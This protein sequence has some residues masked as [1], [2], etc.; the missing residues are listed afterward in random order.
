MNANPATIPTFA[1]ACGCFA[2]GAYCYARR[3]RLSLVAGALLALPCALAVF[4]YTHLLDHAVWYFELRTVP[5]IELAFSGVGFLGGALY[6]CVD[7]ES[8]M[9]RLAVPAAFAVIVLVPF[10]KPILEPLNVAALQDK[11]KGTVCLQSSGSTCGPA[12]AATLLRGLGMGVT[13]R[14]LAVESYTY[15]GGTE[16]WYLARAIRRRGAEAEF[17]F[18]D[19]TLPSPS[20]A[21]VQ[22]GGGH[23]IA[24][25][26]A[27]PQAVTFVDPLTGESTATPAQLRAR[28][29]FTGFFL[30]VR[31]SGK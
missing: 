30:Q 11:C 18:S 15:P 10:M 3:P 7:A 9:G 16:A 17:I 5:W 22:M 21:G 14:E 8:R 2:A 12:S 23:F 25:E 26:R 24:I 4:Y 13:E 31:P 29:R 27:T 6:R 19:D 1:L 20:I 28:Y